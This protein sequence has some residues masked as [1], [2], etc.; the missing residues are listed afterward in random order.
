M[1]KAVCAVTSVSVEEYEKGIQIACLWGRR[2]GPLRADNRGC[3]VAI[4]LTD[5][6]VA[7][8][9]SYEAPA[10]HP[11]DDSELKYGWQSSPE[12]KCSPTIFQARSRAE[13]SE[14]WQSE[15]TDRQLTPHVLLPRSAG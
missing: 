6:Q 2:S 12:G 14:V 15:E 1:T 11:L 7:K 8:A 10:Y 3:L 9:R 4:P 13:F 5:E